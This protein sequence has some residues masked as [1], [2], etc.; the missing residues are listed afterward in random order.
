MLGGNLLRGVK[1]EGFGDV[2]LPFEA[3]FLEKRFAYS[4][5]SY[6]ASEADFP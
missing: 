4:L 5:L 2:L 1:E 3:T 6:K